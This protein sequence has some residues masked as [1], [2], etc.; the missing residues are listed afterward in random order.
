[1]TAPVVIVGSGLAGWTVARELR[2]LD[3]AVPIVMV[4]ASPG[5]FYAKPT[6]SNALALARSSC[7]DRHHPRGADGRRIQRHATG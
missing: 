6:L 7:A 3:A 2:K 1:M 4:T 5:H